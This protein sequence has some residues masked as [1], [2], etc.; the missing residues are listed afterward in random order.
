MPFSIL[1]KVSPL[2]L[3]V[4]SFCVF[5]IISDVSPTRINLRRETKYT[6]WP[7]SKRTL[8]IAKMMKDEKKSP[9]SSA[10]AMSW[11]ISTTITHCYESCGAGYNSGSASA[12]TYYIHSIP[13]SSKKVAAI[14]PAVSFPITCKIN[15][16]SENTIG[17]YDKRNVVGIFTWEFARNYKYVEL[18][19]S[20]RESPALDIFEKDSDM[21]SE[22]RM[23]EPYFEL[24]ESKKDSIGSDPIGS[25]L[26][27]SVNQGPNMHKNRVVFDISSA[28][29]YVPTERYKEIEKT[30]KSIKKLKSLVDFK[31]GNQSVMKLLRKDFNLLKSWTKSHWSFG[32][33]FFERHKITFTECRHNDDCLEAKFSRIGG[34]SLERIHE[35]PH[36]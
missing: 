20:S 18:D 16:I 8:F 23:N 21:D 31:K 34:R 6:L 30:M 36:K 24:S 25:F 32:Y 35:A 15:L 2:V 1:L 13:P 26:N 27:V 19:L 9:E 11:V 28:D 33:R 4:T 14:S 7:Y 17:L 10:R 22:F 5:G 12:E 3:L 29:I